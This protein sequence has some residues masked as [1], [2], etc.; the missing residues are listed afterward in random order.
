[1]EPSRSLSVVRWDHKDNTGE[2]SQRHRKMI[3]HIKNSAHSVDP[4]G[5]IPGGPFWWPGPSA[6]MHTWD[7]V[8]CFDT[9]TR[10][11]LE[12]IG[13]GRMSHLRHGGWSVLESLSAQSLPCFGMA[14]TAFHQCK[15][16]SSSVKWVNSKPVPNFA[17]FPK[18]RPWPNSWKSLPLQN[19]WNNP[20]TH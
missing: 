18:S 3:E 11:H 8:R 7:F 15:P 16:Q 12:V 1:M 17:G 5:H 10:A 20:L 2:N 13:P 9:H 19:S 14:D 4:K 6:W